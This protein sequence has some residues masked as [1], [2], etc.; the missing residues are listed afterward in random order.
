MQF[1]LTESTFHP[2]CPNTTRST[3]CLTS[4]PTPTTARS[5]ATQWATAAGTWGRSLMDRAT[6]TAGS[7]RWAAAA[8]WGTWASWA[9]PRARCVNQSTITNPSRGI[10]LSSS[11]GRRWSARRGWTAPRVKDL[12][13]RRVVRRPSTPSAA[14]VSRQSRPR[15]APAPL[16]SPTTAT[17]ACSASIAST[18]SRTTRAATRST[19]TTTWSARVWAPKRTTRPRFPRCAKR[20]SSART[21][22]KLAPRRSP[23]TAR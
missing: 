18:R 1:S 12:A 22:R 20:D 11:Q 7:S 10:R 19:T 15:P 23:C 21:E 5:S 4:P 17:R 3:A 14:P 8:R 16:S 6:V 2:T 9:S 13:R